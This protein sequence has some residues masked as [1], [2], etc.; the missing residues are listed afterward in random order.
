MNELPIDKDS[1]QGWRAKLLI[2][3]LAQDTSTWHICHWHT[4]D[5]LIIWRHAIL[6]NQAIVGKCTVFL[7]PLVNSIHF[8]FAILIHG[9]DGILLWWSGVCTSINLWSGSKCLQWV[10]YAHLTSWAYLVA[11]QVIGEPL[12]TDWIHSWVV[13][14][15]QYIMHM[16]LISCMLC[17]LPTHH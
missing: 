17:P 1:M 8:A 3:M 6:F 11:W 9:W 4:Y 13:S 5:I 2:W 7:L 15:V 10:E 16:I 12:L 14:T